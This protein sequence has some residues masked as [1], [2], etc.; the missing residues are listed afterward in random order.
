MDPVVRP[1]G[2]PRHSKLARKGS[3]FGA[4]SARVALAY[5]L[6]P[7]RGACSSPFLAWCVPG[8]V[9]W[10]KS[11]QRRADCILA[12]SAT[13]LY[14]LAMTGYPNWHGGWSLGSRYLLPVL[15]FPAAAIGHALKTPLSRGLFAAAVVFS[16]AAHFVLTSSFPYFPDNVAWPAATD[17]CGF[18]REVGRAEPARRLSG[19]ASA[20]LLSRGLLRRGARVARRAMVPRRVVDPARPRPACGAAPAA[21][22]SCRSGLALARGH[23]RRVFGPGPGRRELGAVALTAATPAE[24]RQAVGAWRRYG[25]PPPT[26]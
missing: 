11:G 26:P 15:F 7:A 12:L 4:P 3:G 1:G 20:L 9:V 24:R 18:S 19:A 5:L 10:W 16:V 13:A 6:H 17:R 25:P 2:V 21:L 14:F 8:F 23:L 22:P